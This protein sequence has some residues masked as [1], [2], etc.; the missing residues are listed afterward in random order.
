[1]GKFG[2]AL[3]FNGS[4]D[5]AWFQDANF[6]VGAQGS[7]SFWVQMNDTSRRNQF[8]EGPGNN[9]FEFQY[10][11]LAATTGQLFSSPN[12]EGD[13]ANSAGINRS[14][15]QVWTNLQFTW[16]RTSTTSGTMHIYVNG[17]EVS[18]V[19][20]GNPATTFDATITNWNAV[21]STV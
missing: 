16:Q 21:V 17:T 19:V 2:G 4:T 5:F 1:L 3:Q 8:V 20:T 14:T 12:N 13:R 18:Y 15:F 6:D 11:T 7:L 10:N 9:G